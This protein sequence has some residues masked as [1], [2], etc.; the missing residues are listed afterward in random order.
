M[1]V[2]GTSVMTD[3]LMSRFA[4]SD[5]ICVASRTV[6]PSSTLIMVTSAK[7][8]FTVLLGAYKLSY[9]VSKGW[10]TCPMRKD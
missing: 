9:G 8:A 3:I 10:R 1:S 6:L 7:L 5:D 2:D 4:S